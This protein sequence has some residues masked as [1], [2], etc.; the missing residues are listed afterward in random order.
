MVDEN[1]F[2]RNVTLRICGHLEI[3][4]GLQACFQYIS[5]HLPA[6]RIYLERHEYEL[7]LDV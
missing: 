2:F 3:E 6:D 7:Y 1:E 5:Q 4:E